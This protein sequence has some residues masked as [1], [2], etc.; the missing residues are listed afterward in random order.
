MHKDVV[1][2]IY[3]FEMRYR[4]SRYNGEYRTLYKYSISFLM[5]RHGIRIFNY[6]YKTKDIWTWLFVHNKNGATKNELPKN[7]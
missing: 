3:Y 4:K 5:Y 1:D 7:Y 2:L 6:R